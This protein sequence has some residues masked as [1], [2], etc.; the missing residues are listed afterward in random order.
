MKT[1]YIIYDP[2]IDD[3]YTVFDIDTAKTYL[4]EH[5]FAILHIGHIEDIE[6][7]FSKIKS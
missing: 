6:E 1:I 2:E 3:T 7:K 4:E 5:P